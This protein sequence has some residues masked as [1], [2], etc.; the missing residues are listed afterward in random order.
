ML[1]DKRQDALGG[2]MLTGV[3]LC[4]GNSTR[5]GN[6]KGL[7]IRNGQPWA[8]IAAKKLESLT[9]PVVLSVN[10][11]QVLHYSSFFTKEQ[12]IVD[13]DT[14]PVKGPL[15]GLLSVH[16]KFPTEDL[17]VLAC[18]M[19]DMTVTLLQ[20][21]HHQS[22]QSNHDAFIYLTGEKIQPLCGI[23]TA[24]GLRRIQTLLQEG[25]LKK[26]SMM[27]VLENLDTKYIQTKKEHEPPFNNYNTPADL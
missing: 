23:Y 12:L 17:F 26:F 24:K 19:K 7:L 10:K 4:G 27:H 13:E 16:Q 5:M 8:E 3:V 20:N 2:L 1:I 14:I 21:L 18:D 22:K 25:G 6:D 9:M 11:E 15:L